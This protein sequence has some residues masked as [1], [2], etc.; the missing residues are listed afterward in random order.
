VLVVLG[1]S[2]APKLQ[3]VPAPE[4]LG[5]IAQYALGPYAAPIVCIAVVL[6]CITTAIVLTSLFSDFLRKEVAK[7]KISPMLSILTTLAIGFCI[8]TLEFAGIMGFIGP[9]LECIYPALIVMTLFSLAYK[10]L[11]WKAVRVPT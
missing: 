1:A 2:Y 10:T 7:E 6:A 3:G 8:S 11:G 5:M 9:I 4:M